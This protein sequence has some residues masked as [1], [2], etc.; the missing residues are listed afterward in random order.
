MKKI[1]ILVISTSGLAKKEGISTIILDNFSRFDKKNFEFHIIADGMYSYQLVQEFN[2]AG[3]SIKYLPS[4]K[5]C[6]V[7]YVKAFIRLFRAE[8]YD[9]LYI[10]G[11]SAIMSIELLVAKMCGCKVRVVHSHNTTCTHRKMDKFLRPLFYHLY[12]DAL[13]CGE[14]AGR[15]LYGNREFFVVKNGRDVQKYCFRKEKRAEVRYQLGVNED[16]LLIGHVGNFV[17][18]KNQQFILGIFKELRAL[19]P[20]AKLYLMGDGRLFD[21]VKK[22]SDELQISDDVVF[23]GS[24]DNVDEML[25]AM[26]VMVLPSLHEGLPLVVIEWQIAALPCLISDKIT[27]ECSYSDLVHYMSLDNEYIDWARKLIEIAHFDRDMA[28]NMMIERTKKNGYDINQNAI[29]L[30][31]FFIKKCKG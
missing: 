17:K 6:V 19:Y 14:D 21:E 20:N 25:Q 5:A 2:T 7:Q 31:N 22:I 13:A 26:D 18:Q 4:R 27:K 23:T 24:I 11:S 29:E 8:R 16:T 3:V 15:W 1:K 30:Q 12:T 28:S 9:A 10:H